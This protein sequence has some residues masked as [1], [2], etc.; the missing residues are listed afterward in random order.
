LAQAIDPQIKVECVFAPPEHPPEM[1][2]KW[3]FTL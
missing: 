3:R 1:F 2:C